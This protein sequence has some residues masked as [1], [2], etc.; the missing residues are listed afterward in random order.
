MSPAQAACLAALAVLGETSADH[1]ARAARLGALRGRAA[2]AA[3]SALRRAG[4]VADA[5]R[6]GVGRVWSLTE[7]GRALVSPMH[8][9]Q[10]E[11]EPT[12]A[13]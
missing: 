6:A 9:G 12:P 10:G 4:L 11:G 3:L 7:A 13:A 1:I 2:L 5:H 8:L